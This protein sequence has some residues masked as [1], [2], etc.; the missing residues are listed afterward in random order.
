MLDS[1]K[2]LPLPSEARELIKYAKKSVQDVSKLTKEELATS[3]Y[4]PVLAD[5]NSLIY[6]YRFSS[7]LV[8]AEKFS[9]VRHSALI[10]FNRTEIHI[11]SHICRGWDG[12][13]EDYYYR[14]S[15]NPPK[16]END[17]PWMG[18]CLATFTSVTRSVAD[19]LN[20]GECLNM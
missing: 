4:I 7:G 14:Q 12:P 17:L 19:M 18:K 3:A 6:K 9:C 11:T 8:L 16:F 1:Y 13:I 15:L 10:I 5:A 20:G 2:N